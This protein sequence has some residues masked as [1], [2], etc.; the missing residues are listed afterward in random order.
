MI[1]RLRFVCALA[2]LMFSLTASAQPMP[3][4]AAPLAEQLLGGA[5]REHRASAAIFGEVRNGQVVALRGWGN[6]GGIGSPAVDVRQTRFP[7]ASITKTL[8]AIAIARLVE[9]GRIRSLDDPVNSYLKHFQLPDGPGRAITLR[10]LLT[11]RSGLDDTNFGLYRTRDSRLY[12]LPGA[13]YAAM[14]PRRVREAGRWPAYSNFGVAILGAVVEDVGGTSYAHTVVQDVFRPLGMAGA[15]L[16]V[17][18]HAPANLIVPQDLTDPQHP[19]A[20]PVR[21]DSLLNL[22]SGG[23]VMTAAD[24][25]RYVQALVT[26]PDI[27]GVLGPRGTAMLTTTLAMTHPAMSGHAMLFETQPVGPLLLLKHGGTTEGV[28][29]EMFLARAARSGLFF[30]MTDWWHGRGTVLPADRPGITL[31]LVAAFLGDLTGTDVTKAAAMPAAAAPPGDTGRYAGTYVSARSYR[32]SAAA[33]LSIFALNAVVVET[34][35]DGLRI[36]GAGG[37]REVAPGLFRSAVSPEAIAFL[38]NGK[39]FALVRQFRPDAYLPARWIERP[40]VA[41]GLLAGGVAALMIAL[42]LAWRGARDQSRTALVLSL[43]AVGGFVA[44]LQAP[45]PGVAPLMDGYFAGDA[46]RFQIAAA[47][48]LLAVVMG[49]AGALLALR[50]VDGRGRALMTALF[51]AA[52]AGTLL[53]LFVQLHL[54]GIARL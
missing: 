6:T 49:A 9:A 25:A 14:M 2:F 22:P 34:A 27:P 29:C 44:A 3:D 4:T 19:V 30:C 7:V 51:A 23:A 33:V 45:F 10:D 43:V 21:P 31:Q 24:L 17:S 41:V 28:W 39:G 46:T 53:V 42:A 37:Y 8:T 1:A 38:P 54:L 36:G 16:P 40:H 26:G 20:R 52:A 11:H 15:M 35:P 18:L 5:V 47:L 48:A 13:A 50:N 32:A 12:P